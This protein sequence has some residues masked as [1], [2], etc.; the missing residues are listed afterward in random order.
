MFDEE[1]KAAAF[2]AVSVL[3][4][5][6]P[7]WYVEFGVGLKFGFLDGSDLD[8]VLFQEAGEF[9]SFV[10]YSLAVQLEEFQ[11]VVVVCGVCV[12]LGVFRGVL[13]CVVGCVLLGV[14]VWVIC[15]LF[16]AVCVRF[17]LRCGGVREVAWR[18]SGGGV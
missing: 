11:V 10:A 4:Q 12:R 17:C 9:G 16:L 5:D 2:V 1:G 3:S 7:V 6:G 8:V 13:C 18:V 15:R 14:C